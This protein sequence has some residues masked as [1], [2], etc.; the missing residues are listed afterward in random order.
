MRRTVFLLGFLLIGG[1]LA[2][3]SAAALRASDAISG[4]ERRYNSLSGLQMQFEQSMEYGGRKRLAE[5]G[6]LY[7]Q[8]PGRMRWDYTDPDGKFA[9]SDG[10]LFKM[11]SP[12]SNQV[13]QVQLE[14]MN[15][16]RA[17]LSF[18]LGRMRIRRMFRNVDLE[19]TD[20]RT[21]LVGQGRR[22]DFYT[23][24][25]FD[26]DPEDFS[27]DGIRIHGRD[28]S[29]HVY[30]FSDERTNPAL[31]AQIFEFVAPKGAEVLP[32]S[33]LPSGASPFEGL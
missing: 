1:M 14:A 13:R 29:V 17:P 31:E 4:V 3:T 32:E 28:E 8:R 27:I 7:L 22:Q 25:E 24:V 15:D 5:K 21:V 12:N 10:K 9:V 18:L 2:S 30:R 16:L 6:T 20:G 26:I 23:R 33:V 11:Y 19:E